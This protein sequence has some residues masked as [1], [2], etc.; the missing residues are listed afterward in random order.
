MMKAKMGINFVKLLLLV[1]LTSTTA[2]GQNTDIGLFVGASYYLGEINPGTQLINQPEPIIGVFIRKNFNKR[3]AFRLGL[4]YGYLSASEQLN[5][6]DIS[7]FRKISFSTSIIEA[8]GFLEFNFFPY[9]IGNNNNSIIT[10]FVFL[11]AAVFR[12]NPEVESDSVSVSSAGSLIAPSIPFGVGVKLNISRNIGLTMEWNMKKTLSDLVDGLPETY[13]NSYQL[14]N[15][16][17]KDWYS[18]L[19]ITLN[20][21]ILTKSDHCRGPVN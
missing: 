13:S 7:D 1:L 11:G 16:E 3:Y 14:S 12:V 17:S 8:S 18:F 9:E 6:T 5:T 19:G 2:I 15:T 21:K 20:Y 4:N 10:P